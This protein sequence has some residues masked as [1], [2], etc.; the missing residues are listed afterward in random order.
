[1]APLTYLEFHLVFIVPPLVLLAWSLRR[2]AARGTLA[3]RPRLALLGTGLMALFAVLYT[4][5]WDNYLISRGV[6]WYP[7]GVVAATFGH[8]PLGEYLFF[9]LQPVLT[10]L[11]LFHLREAATAER[12]VNARG[13][14]VI[15]WLGCTALGNLLFG[16]EWG[17]YLGAILLWACPVAALQWAVGGPHLW[18]VRRTLL[19]AVAV[20][21]AYLWVADATAITLGLW[22]LSPV[23]TTGLTVLSLPVEEALFFLLTNVLVV[24]GV[25]LLYWVADDVSL[26]RPRL[27]PW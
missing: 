11:W 21:T 13:G 24:Q 10:L 1:M 2:R 14:G 7:D 5:P 17:L 8:A 23:H 25:L 9:V 18:R 27:A 6:W 15:L 16:T 20:P 19:V 12:A 3:G 26:P 22:R 4:T